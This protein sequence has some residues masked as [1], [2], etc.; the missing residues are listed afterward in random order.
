MG[1]Q[2]IAIIRRGHGNQMQQFFGLELLLL[3]SL[4]LLVRGVDIITTIAGSTS[5]GYSGD[6]GAATAA[7]L[8]FPYGVAIDTSGNN[9]FSSIAQM[10]SI[11]CYL[12]DFISVTR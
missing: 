2:I 5:G 12:L 10:S 3:T 6:G 1:C 11:Q 8:A 4:I 9:I 7:T